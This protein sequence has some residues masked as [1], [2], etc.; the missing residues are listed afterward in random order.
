MQKCD[1]KYIEITLLH[2]Y[3]SVNMPHICTRTPF[4]EDS[5]RKL[6]PYIVQNIEVMNVKV[7]SK[8]VK[9]FEIHFNNKDTFSNFICEFH[10][11]A[12]N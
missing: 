7:L 11:V 10:L 9:N 2:E 6:L 8:Q 3:S 12:K 4:I 5:S 1:L